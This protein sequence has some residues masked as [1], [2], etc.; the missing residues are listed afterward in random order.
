MNVNTTHT[1]A[2][3]HART[4]A[5][6]PTHSHAYTHEH[7]HTHA[8]ARA[9]AHTPTYPHPRT[10]KITEH[11]QERRDVH[12]GIKNGAKCSNIEKKMCMIREN[13][14]ALRC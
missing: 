12:R 11:L 4:H 7:P 13:I 3:M 14:E 10:K 5:R 9:R 8:R 1:H 6:T 2:R